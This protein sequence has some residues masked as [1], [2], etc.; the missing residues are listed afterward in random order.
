MVFE[1]PSCI[2]LMEGWKRTR[3]MSL[4]IWY[5][6]ALID[7]VISINAMHMTLC[8][9]QSYHAEVCYPTSYLQHKVLKDRML[10][11]QTLPL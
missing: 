2:L 8:L 3:C 4:C 7:N 6:I 10:F 11:L 5:N 9:H 1:N